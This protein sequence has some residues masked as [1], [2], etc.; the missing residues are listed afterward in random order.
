MKSDGKAGLTDMSPGAVFQRL[1]EASDLLALCVSLGKARRL[2][3][4][5]RR[6][7]A[8][9]DRTLENPQASDPSTK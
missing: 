1:R 3:P 2:G 9:A 6:G 8:D 4:V 7:E 5:R